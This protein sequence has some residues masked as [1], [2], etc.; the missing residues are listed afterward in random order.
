MLTPATSPLI[1]VL[2]QKSKKAQDEFAAKHTTAKQWLLDRGLDLRQLRAHSAKLLTGATLSSALLLA[3]PH[4]QLYGKSGTRQVANLPLREFLRELNQ[5]K[6]LH[7]EN[8]IELAIGDQIKSYYG[9]NVAFELDHNRLP[10]YVGKIGLEQHLLRHPNDALAQHGD[11]LEA[12]MAPGKGAFGYFG[13]SLNPE[14]T[15]L[16]EKYY[17]V[18]ETF[19]IPNWNR[20]WVRLKE[21]YKFRKF[22]IINLNTGQ[23][24]VAVLGDAGPAS[25]TGK[26]FG[27][28]P[29]V[30][31]AL[32]FYPQATRGEV[33]VFFLDDPAGQIPVGPLQREE[34]L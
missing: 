8:E 19:L 3:S 25:W 2:A 30:M 5:L 16:Y 12:G 26:K 28:S 31:A 7:L 4:I 11:F 15:I 27:G 22:V 21:W 29:E 9:V 1:D 18:L 23:G 13:D 10:D 33:A 14:Q 20:D 24:V 32:G 34:K 17:L 6:Q